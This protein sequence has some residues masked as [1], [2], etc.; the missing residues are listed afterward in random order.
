MVEA[1]RAYRRTCSWSSRQSRRIPAAIAQSFLLFGQCTKMSLAPP[2][3]P[4]A[5]DPGVE[6][7]A[8]AELHVVA[9]PVDQ[10]DQLRLRSRRRRDLMRDLE[11]TPERPSPDRRA[12]A[13]SPTE[14]G[15]SGPG[16]AGRSPTRSSY[17]ELAE[18]LLDVLN[19]ERALLELVLRDVIF[20]G[21]PDSI[22]PES[23]IQSA[24]ANGKLENLKSEIWKL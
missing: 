23:A 12:A 5:A 18:E 3:A 15:E 11:G 7:A 2:V 8:A 19:L 16:G 10:V 14:S 24:T 17:E 6:H 20:H 22:L 4:G 1:C 13:R 21:K 9:Q